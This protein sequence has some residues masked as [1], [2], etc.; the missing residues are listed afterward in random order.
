GTCIL[1][2][3]ELIDMPSWLLDVISLMQHSAMGIHVHCGTESNLV[4]L[5][6]LGS[7]ETRLCLAP[8]GYVGQAGELWFVRLL[9]PA[10]A[11]FNYHIVFNTP[12]ILVGITERMFLGYLNREVGRIGSRNPPGKLEAPAYIMK[13]GPT[14]TTGT[15]IFSAL[16]RGTNTR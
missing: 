9:P 5:R 15:N 13:H 4:R 11:L 12:Y 8:S 1:R 16:I 3:G 10:N 6:A 7:Q 2:I 14:L